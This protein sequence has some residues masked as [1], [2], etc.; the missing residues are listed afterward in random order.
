MVVSYSL[1]RIHLSILWKTCIGRVTSGSANA[2][3]ST[4]RFSKSRWISTNSKS[5]LSVNLSGPS[6]SKR[7][8][9]K[10]MTFWGYGFV[11][12]SPYFLCSGLS[13]FSS[14]DLADLA[15]CSCPWIFRLT[16]SLSSK[17]SKLILHMYSTATSTNCFH[18]VIFGCRSTFTS[19]DLNGR[20][21]ATPATRCSAG[22]G[23]PGLK[24]SGGCTTLWARS[25]RNSLTCGKGLDGYNF[26]F[27][28][29]SYRVACRT[30]LSAC[31][32]RM[33][34][35]TIC[36]IFALPCAAE[37]LTILGPEIHR[38]ICLLCSCE[39]CVIW[40]VRNLEGI[41]S[42]VHFA[43]EE[44]A[45][46]PIVVFLVSARSRLKRG[47]KFVHIDAWQ[48]DA[49]PR[50]VQTLDSQFWIDGQ[51]ELVLGP[52]RILESMCIQ[53]CMLPYLY[54][55]WLV[56]PN[57]KWSNIG[58][59]VP[60]FLETRNCCLSFP[61]LFLLHPP[62]CAGKMLWFDGSISYSIGSAA[63][64]PKSKPPPTPCEADARV[65]GCRRGL[66]GLAATVCQ[67]S[68][69][70]GWKGKVSCCWYLWDPMELSADSMVNCDSRWLHAAGES[71]EVRIL[72]MKRVSP[73]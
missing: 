30:S 35:S 34:K 69:I 37:C 29:S 63:N 13:W 17:I 57:R 66:A 73:L 26:C 44:G 71:E 11:P 62:F 9:S 50:V 12:V 10:P 3:T 40:E 47:D 72:T 25:G 49:H 65:S 59:G 4:W 8:N 67:S 22:S 39:A 54:T 20:N 7:S 38:M 31:I 61:L 43:V 1:S 48:T 64:I 23:Q 19:N 45:L 21:T 16:P 60:Q 15:F 52:Q 28:T 32:I 36:S 14:L 33:C 2:Q 41:S 6:F 46:E 51:A 58:F 68:A 55:D 56:S 27:I 70:A 42:L 5:F 24:T 53:T 18:N